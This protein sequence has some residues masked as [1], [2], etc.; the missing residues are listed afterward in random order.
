MT[1]EKEHFCR[2]GGTV[3]TRARPG[4]DTNALPG[5]R[6]VDW[7]RIWVQ[8][9][10][11]RLLARNVGSLAVIVGPRRSLLAPNVSRKRPL[12]ASLCAAVCRPL[13]V[14]SAL[15]LLIRTLKAKVRA[16]L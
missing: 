15:L 7:Q 13:Q 8:Q 2:T 3:E 4:D 9:A 16:V 11:C 10:V 6:I 14:F 12:F 5:K 1:G